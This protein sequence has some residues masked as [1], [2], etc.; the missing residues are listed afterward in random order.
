ME[1]KSTE[2]FVQDL[3]TL[4]RLGAM[5]GLTDGQLL[6]RFAAG[7]DVAEAAFEGIVRR[8]GPMVLGVCRRALGDAH[9]A[10]DAFQATFLVLAF[11]ARAIIQRDSLGPW[12]HGVAFRLACRTRFLTRRRP[13]RSGLLPE[14]ASPE[15]VNGDLA[16]LRPVLDE[17]LGRLPEKYR[18]PLVLCYLQGLTQE[19]AARS[20]GW[21]KGTI[22]GRLARAKELLRGRLARRGLA[23]AAGLLVVGAGTGSE[24]ATLTVPSSLVAA[25]T[26]AAVA[27]VLGAAETGA[28]SGSVLRL[29]RAVLRSML[30]GRIKAAAILLMVGALGGAVAIGYAGPAE[31]PPALRERPG[32]AAVRPV[33]PTLPQGARLRLGTTLLRHS[34]VYQAKFSPDG[35]TLIS[36]GGDRMVRFWDPKTG[37]PIPGVDL[38]KELTSSRVMDVS[39]DGRLLVLGREDGTVQLWD[40]AARRERFRSQVHQGEVV[41]LAFAPDGLTFASS[42]RDDSCVRLWDVA[43]GIELRTLEFGEEQ[44]SCG[45]LVFSPDGDR[46]AVGTLPGTGSGDVTLR[47]WDRRGAGDQVIIPVAHGYQL[48]GL[49]FTKDSKALISGG[50]EWRD[51]ED[52]LARP[53]RK[54]QTLRPRLALWDVRDGGKLWEQELADASDLGGFT[55]AE[56]GA[57]L[58]SAHKDQLRVWDIASGR[59][60][61][62]IPIPL[63]ETHKHASGVA[64]SPDDQT[65]ALLRHDNRIRLL[66]FNS[67]QPRPAQGEGHETQVLSVAFT[68]DGRTLATSGADGSVRVWDGTNGVSRGHFKLGTRGDVRA[69]CVS[70]DGQTLAAAGEDPDSAD[71]D[72][73]TQWVG[74]VV[75][76]WNLADGQLRREFK[77]DHR[78]TH[79]SFAPDS[80]R[81]AVASWNAEAELGMRG[82]ADGLPDNT[83]RVFDVET[84]Q[85]L[86]ELKGRGGFGENIV[87]FA[88]KP[89]GRSIVAAY[90]DMLFQFWD[91]DTGKVTRQ[92]AIEGHTATG[93]RVRLASAAFSP[94]LKWALTSASR[95]DRL[96]V[97]DLNSGKEEQA[98][99]HEGAAGPRVAI[100]PDGQRFCTVL[101]AKNGE[102]VC[103]KFWDKA[104]GRPSL[105]LPIGDQPVISLAF[106]PD[107]RSLATGM[108]DTTAIVWDLVPPH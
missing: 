79:V 47:I 67:G 105:S 98:I 85:M 29:A 3:S 30:V 10:E 66:D 87:A 97:W 70:P 52:L 4:F 42:S 82:E 45:P 35:R 43:K 17:E 59:V 78:A 34:G 75:R 62:T 90:E 25:T 2:N 51:V 88:F 55:L 49:A 46:V 69:V 27:V 99:R 16:D 32:T 57:T 26:R 64:I 92:L 83:I 76:V 86:A 5:A 13:E 58:V 93:K 56:Q 94:D 44:N 14:L 6:D 20:L 39:P 1:E 33:D 40:I 100:T 48:A 21:T 106:A 89:D 11:R 9:A 104:S 96:I 15:A 22:S 38:P 108:S 71:P 72:A 80:R 7:G 18:R 53:T 41:G 36:A 95:D 101:R 24:A 31:D 60:T 61:R 23:P 63:E 28:V 54:K 77:L 91:L 50:H 37:K 8:H 74:G 19:E 102:D 68:P 84:G 12:L 107:G 81:L 65:I 103:I 73:D